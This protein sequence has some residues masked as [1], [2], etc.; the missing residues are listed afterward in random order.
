[1]KYPN[2]YKG[3]TNV[4]ISETLGFIAAAVTLLSVIF[5]F[6][7]AS[8]SSEAVELDGNFPIMIVI[9]IIGV[10]A[11]VFYL[12]G[13]V[14]A[15]KD[16]DEFKLALIFM[17]IALACSMVAALM[18]GV[19]SSMEEMMEFASELLELVAFE[20]VVTGVVHFAKEYHD[21]KI[22][23]ISKKMR[24]I[25]TVVWIAVIAGKFLEIVSGDLSEIAEFVFEIMEAIDHIL[26][27]ILLYKARKMLAGTYTGSE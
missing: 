18:E 16:E 10:A 15:R 7:A 13:L 8:G 20:N 23:S 19:D 3:L 21:E 2:T 4:F 9:T 26:F 25:I 1:M 27:M 11:L 6:G 24:I 12:V 14:Q 5:L 17:G 22:L